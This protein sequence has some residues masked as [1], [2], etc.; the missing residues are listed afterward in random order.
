MQS[1]VRAV[2]DPNPRHRIEQF[3]A[4][5]AQNRLDRQMQSL[6]GPACYFGAVTAFR[7]FKPVRLPHGWF[8]TLLNLSSFQLTLKRARSETR[9]TLAAAALLA[10]RLHAFDLAGVSHVGAI[11]DSM[12][13]FSILLLWVGSSVGR[14]AAF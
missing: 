8:L 12:S 9:K 3:L 5:P 11:P 13:N 10:Y 7:T 4:I 6:I 2:Q 1:D 14:A